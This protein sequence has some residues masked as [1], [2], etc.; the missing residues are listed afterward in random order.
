MIERLLLFGATGDLARRFLLPALAALHAQ[1]DLPGGFQILG[2]ATRKGDD[3]GFRRQVAEGLE[4]HAG[5]LPAAS[6][7]AVLGALRYRQTDATDPQS[8]AAA[9]AA[10]PG[11]GPLAAYLALPPGLFAPAVR[12]LGAA[13]LPPGSRVV[14]EK[15][16]GENLEGA[17]SL[18]ALLA[19]TY[20]EEAERVVF[21]VDHVLGMA[22]VQNLL[23][24]R[25]ANRV[26]QA[27]WT[28]E[29]IEQIEIL[30]EETLA[31]EGRAGY[32]D[33]TGALKDVLQ[34]HMLQVLC[35]A[36]MEP[37]AS[38]NERDLRDAKVAALR[39]V[40]SLTPQAVEEQTRRA[41]YTAGR[42][43]DTGGAGGG[44]VPDYAAEE[45]VDPSRETETWAEVVLELDTPRW[46]GTRFVLRAGKALSAR[47][48]GIVVR[49]RAAEPSPF[50]E[51][52]DMPP[53]EWRIGL[54]GPTDLGLHLSG[55]SAGS[56]PQPVPLALTGPPP[57]S[58][59]P[60]YARV[61]RDV[62]AGGS[63]LSVRGDEAE[64]AWRVVTPVLEGW[65]AGRVPLEEYPAGSSGPGDRSQ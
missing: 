12:A 20:G 42:L 58:G 39:S 36:A 3:E 47:R 37:P 25:F 50:G 38:L 13:G 24:L 53:N 6:R 49:F 15:P 33:G 35:F 63:A 27:L 52:E 54:D 11:E 4:E 32:Y 60:P 31:L 17:R 40:R 62:L 7:E 59:L 1:G 8:V 57:E 28:G 55:L 5:D 45:G 51:S 30:W 46:Q 56:R 18:N 65:A 21:R 64:E 41:R 26:A 19:D 29:H 23:G 34:N 10:L 14:L 2:A 48:K 44:E 61:L 16:F 22:P 43:A 9:L